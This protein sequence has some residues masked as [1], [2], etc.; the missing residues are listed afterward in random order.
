M[1]IVCGID[2]SAA[3]REAARAAA[4]LAR[5][6]ESKLVLVH[7]QEAVVFTPSMTGTPI[8]VGSTVELDRDRERWKEELEREAER[9]A[10][11]FG[12][13]VE[14]RIRTGLPDHEL[15]QVAKDESADTVVVASVG[16]RASTPWRFGSVADRLTQSTF[17]PL[18]VVR[19]ARAFERWALE[20]RG[21]DIVLALGG[22]W[23]TM[24]AVREAHA[25]ASRGPGQLT[26][27]HVYDPRRE[28]RRLGLTDPDEPG[29]RHTIESALARELPRRYGEEPGGKT[30]S[31]VTVPAAGDVAETVAEAAEARHADLLIVGSRGFNAWQRRFHHS[32][33][34]A[35]VPQVETNVLVVPADSADEG[36]MEAVPARVTSVLVATDLADTG[37]RGLDFALGLLPDGGRLAVLHVELPPQLPAGMWTSYTPTPY[38]APEERRHQRHVVEERLRA[39]LAELGRPLELEVEVVEADDVPRAILE[40]AERHCVDLVCL[41]THRYGRVTGALIGS[42]ARVVARRST[43]PV[44]LVPP[45]PD[46]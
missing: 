24:A 1:T 34:Y 29:T 17:L 3:S 8:A 28:A 20:N 27:L 44:L 4:S 18:L 35:V 33:S 46:E 13:V 39:R 30:T 19:D 11:A 16:R 23:P 15:L 6:T 42:V 36:H 22:G 12:L 14:S 25:L 9:L 38:P 5:R 21:L 40:A 32:V 43:R 31:F 26:E 10:Q 7:V 41:G 37:Q 45:A 2:G